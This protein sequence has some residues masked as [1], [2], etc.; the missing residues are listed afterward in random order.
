M[1][2][3]KNVAIKLL[4]M[5][6]SVSIIITSLATGTLA[7]FSA[8][9]TW[10]SD[11]ANAGAFDYV[12]TALSLDLFGTNAI[13]PGD[14]G[15]SMLSGTDFG[16][17]SLSW[18]FSETN[19]SVL[20]VLFYVNDSASLSGFYS[21]Y[22]FSTAF[23]TYYINIDTTNYIA[24]SSI[25]NSSADLASE[26]GMGYNVCWIWP[27]KLYSYDE[28]TY[29]EVTDDEGVTTYLANNESLCKTVV[30]LN[31]NDSEVLTQL[32]NSQ[33]A[34]TNIAVSSITD[35]YSIESLTPA[36]VSVSNG[37]LMY[38]SSYLKLFST[39]SADFIA[40]DANY[41]LTSGD[42]Y[43]LY[44]NAL[45]VSR[46]ITNFSET[47]LNYEIVGNTEGDTD[48]TQYYINELNTQ[49]LTTYNGNTAKPIVKIFPSEI[50]LPAPTI[51]VIITAEVSI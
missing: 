44:S 22:D 18:G 48:F 17:K 31:Y 51:S 14:S 32:T 40:P 37:L 45:T 8:T 20:P 47:D 2:R 16:D 6:F 19:N 23:P 9:Y 46:I 41:V 3:Q 26:F 12:D 24:C 39:A 42:Y 43:L 15:S 30:N 49:I 10:Q 27:D 1:F 38:N 21:S 28:T 33:N 36:Q 34:F 7:V 11:E 4:L 5:L 50:S 35:G 13:Y 25:S 29:T